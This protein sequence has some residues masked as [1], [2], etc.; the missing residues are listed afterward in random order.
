MS[1]LFRQAAISI[2]IAGGLLD[3]ALSLL[4]IHKIF[5][6]WGVLLSLLFFPFTWGYFP[7][8]TLF[9]YRSWNLLLIT[10]GSIAVSLCLLVIA[11]KMET[12]QPPLI[13]PPTK[14]VATS[15]HSVPASVFLAGALILVAFI[16]YRSN[17]TMVQKWTRLTKPAFT[18]TTTAL[19]L[20][21]STQSFMSLKACVPQGSIRI[22]RGPGTQYETIGGLVSGMCMWVLA[23][24]QES[25]WVYI[26]TE[27]D[28][29]G[30][31][32]AWLLTIDGDVNGL[33]VR[34]G[35]EDGV[36]VTTATP[37]P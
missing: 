37:L 31:V 16:L 19:P 25:N 2:A 20:P 30:W 29:S 11:E 6:N 4:V 7:F 10:Y 28:K 23:R 32:A 24:N 15:D 9:A 8:Y 27:N 21:T 3:L 1:R 13:E 18:E 12:R 35:S 33:S 36:I 34:E 22:R 26:V 5:G 14:P 17:S